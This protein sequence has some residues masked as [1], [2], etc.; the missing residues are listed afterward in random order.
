[1]TEFSSP[2]SFEFGWYMLITMKNLA[3]SLSETNEGK[4]GTIFFF[5]FQQ[6]QNNLEKHPAGVLRGVNF[7]R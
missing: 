5:C 4:P 3:Y 1:M 7:L 6:Q 2:T